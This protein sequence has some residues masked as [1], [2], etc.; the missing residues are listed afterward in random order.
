MCHVEG[1]LALHRAL[2]MCLAATALA[3]AGASDAGVYRCQ[4]GGQVV[5]QDQPCSPGWLQ[6]W[7]ALPGDHGTAEELAAA[8][9]TPPLRERRAARAGRPARA[10]LI[11]LQRDPQR[12]DRVRHQRDRALAQRRRAPDLLMQRAW[13]DSVNAACQ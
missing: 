2:V 8:P 13:N 11:R 10:A 1:S 5:H 3:A 7:R 6:Q 9:G 4:S 12:C